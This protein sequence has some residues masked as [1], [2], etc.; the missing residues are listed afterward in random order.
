LLAVFSEVEK[1][2]DSAH[3]ENQ[4]RQFALGNRTASHIA[5]ISAAIPVQIW[6][7]TKLTSNWE[8]VI[9]TTKVFY[10]YS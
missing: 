10:Y 3:E 2:L 7:G 4:P 1:Y 8:T 5:I 9:N 6:D